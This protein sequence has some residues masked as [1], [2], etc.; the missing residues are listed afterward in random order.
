[1]FG[2]RTCVVLS[3]LFVVC[4]MESALA[5]NLNSS[6]CNGL[7]LKTTHATLFCEVAFAAPP[8]HAETELCC[9]EV[10]HPEPLQIADDESASLG[11][12][13]WLSRANNYQGSARQARN[14]YLD[15]LKL[16]LTEYLRASVASQYKAIAEKQTSANSTEQYDPTWPEEN[17][18]FKTVSPGYAS[19][20]TSTTPSP[21]SSDGLQ[22]GPPHS[23]DG[24]VSSQGYA[25]SQVSLPSRNGS[26]SGNSTLAPLA[27]SAHP[28]ASISN[29]EGV[30]TT[31]EKVVYPCPGNCMSTY[32]TWFCKKT[33]SDYE[34]S[35]GRVCC[36]P[37][38]TTIPPEVVVPECTG[39]CIL[40]QLT[41]L[42][43]K[44]ARLL[45]KTTTCSRN[46]ICC[47]ET[48]RLW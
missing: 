14:V 42:C 29:T 44:P 33:S 26:F 10:R 37:I 23:F 25:A 3:V 11:K 46:S 17:D 43:K 19:E 7:C 22:L 24:N 40:P 48:P 21:A 18:I 35:D 32:F 27:E 16:L 47:S 38:T 6:L 2:H 20:T 31:S 1:M 36:L 15:I 12:P 34:C 28:T 30:E 41:G 5:S 45:L 8:C 13:V 4:W 9:G 39:T